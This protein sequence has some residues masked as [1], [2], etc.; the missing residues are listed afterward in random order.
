MAAKSVWKGNLGFGLVQFPV[1]AYKAADDKPE[2]KHFRL[3]HRDC[4][5]PITRPST[6]V[7][8]KVEVPPADFIKGAPIGGNQYVILDAAEQEALKS[9]TSQTMALTTFFKASEVDAIY[10]DRTYYLTPDGVKSVT[11]YMLLHKA[12]LDEGKVGHGTI[13]LNGNDFL[14]IVRPTNTGLVL[15]LL[16]DHSLIRDVEMLAQYADPRSVN[17]D[18]GQ[19]TLVKKVMTKLDGAFKPQTFTNGYETRLKAKIAEKVSGEQTVTVEGAKQTN[20]VSIQGP[21][22]DFL[23]ALQQSVEMTQPKQTPK[24][25]KGRKKA[26]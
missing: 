1:K 19:L 15:D 8:C 9:P 20:V 26:S 25:K 18:A 3:L 2:D 17:L 24:V 7:K 14:F 11:P 23:T 13:S 21:T 4:K 12:L 22:M 10:M 16:R 6:C 5:T